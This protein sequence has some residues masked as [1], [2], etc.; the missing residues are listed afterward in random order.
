[1]KWTPDPELKYKLLESLTRKHTNDPERTKNIHV[2]DLT[3]CLRESY[4]RKTKPKLA[5]EQ[6][7]GYYVDGQRRH[8]V[9][10]D[11]HG[12]EKEVKIGSHGVRATLDLL[13]KVPIEIKTSRGRPA[14]TP[15]HLEQR[16]GLQI[17][18]YMV[19]TNKSAAKFIIQWLNP[20][21]ELNDPTWECYNIDFMNG[22][23]E[24]YLSTLRTSRDLLRVAL[25]SRSPKQLPKVKAEKT[26][27]CRGCQYTEECAKIG[28]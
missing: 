15:T 23:A 2:S 24:L 22:E 7:L 14:L 1:M 12:F 28:G 27:K 11:L 13:D 20:R 10:Q 5:T 3:Y 4:F 25:D 18:Y 26:W 9:V 6:M 16:Y 8:L 19:L 17:G 21:L